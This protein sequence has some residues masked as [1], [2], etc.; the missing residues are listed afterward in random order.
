[1]SAAPRVVKEK[2]LDVKVGQQLI[3]KVETVFDGGM[4]V[5]YRNQHLAGFQLRGALL[6]PPPVSFSP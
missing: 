4:V 2:V 6:T 3:V 5:C 1:M